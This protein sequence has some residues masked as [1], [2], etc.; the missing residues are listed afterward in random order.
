MN[1]NQTPPMPPRRGGIGRLVVVAAVGAG[2]VLGYQVLAGG[3]GHRTAAP[4]GQTAGVAVADNGGPAGS[5]PSGA[6]GAVRGGATGATGAVRLARR[7]PVTGPRLVVV[8]DEPSG[9]FA[10]QNRLITQGA[11]VALAQLNAAGG[12]ARHGVRMVAEQLDGLT[13][14]AVQQRLHAAGSGAVLV[15]PCDAN[16]QTTIAEGA[17]RYGT[18]MLAPCDADAALARTIPTYWP[19]GMAGNDEA[20]GLTGFMQRIGYSSVYVLDTPGLTYASTMTRYFRAAAQARQ[21][22]I[23]GGSTVSLP[24]T[25]AEL[26]AVASAIHSTPT[27]TDAVF[28]AL[29][30]PYIN[31]LAAGLLADGVHQVVLGTSSMDTPLTLSA[32]SRA[33]E[34]ATFPSYGFLSEDDPA[35]SA[36]VSAYRARFG[37]PAGSFPGLGFETIRLLSAAL[38]KARST[39]PA[40]IQQALAAGISLTGVALADRSYK[41][42]ADH[43]PIGTVSVEKISAGAFLPL[44]TAAPT[45]VPGP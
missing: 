39:A 31:Q 44:L 43:N 2:A 12:A 35:T 33:L 14:P 22:R 15:L 16:S 19:V 40:A 18:V 21:L 11:T 9:A 30:P 8:V 6:T 37:L 13:P 32:G 41:A 26:K 24:V 7:T 20:A 29:P 23:T 10:Q 5:G 34:N 25:K 45:D 42:G 28:S 36:F 1:S 4:A 3:G 27:R 17:A 38:A